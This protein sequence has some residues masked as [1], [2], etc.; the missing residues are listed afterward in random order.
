MEQFPQIALVVTAIFVLMSIPMAIAV[1]VRRTKTG[2]SLLHGEDEN[3]LRLMRAHGNFIEYVPLALLALAGA[4]IAGTPSWLVAACGGVL[5]FARL[6]HY[7]SL[8]TSVNGKGRAVGAALTT[9]A[10]LVLALAI[11]WQL[12]IYS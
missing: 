12:W 4:E 10:M 7:F 8:S 9:L 3:L 11:L 6:V 5:L 1:G 2:I